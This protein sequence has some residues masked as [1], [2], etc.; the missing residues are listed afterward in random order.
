MMDPSLYLKV[1]MSQQVYFMIP[2]QLAK[3]HDSECQKPFL[4]SPE[5]L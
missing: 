3:S 2:E 5:Q 1:F 4:S